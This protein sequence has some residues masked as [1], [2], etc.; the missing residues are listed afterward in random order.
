MAKTDVIDAEGLAN[1]GRER[2]GKLAVSQDFPE[3]RVE[4]AALASYPRDSGK[5]NG[6]R[7]TQGRR[8]RIRR[9]LFMAAYGRPTVR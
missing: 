6:C 9:L 2:H 7:R 3:R 4:L 8:A 1:Y 5:T